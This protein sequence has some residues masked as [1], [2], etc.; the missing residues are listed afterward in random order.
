[1]ATRIT[2]RKPGSFDRLESETFTPKMPVRGEA[3]IAVK[4]AGINFADLCV[5]MGVYSSAKQYVGWPITPGFEIAGLVEETG[6][7]C[8]LKKGDRVFGI[9]RFGGYS[10]HITLPETQLFPLPNAW[11]FA[12]GATFPATFL[13][14]YYALF[15]LVHPRPGNRILIHSAAGGV[16]VALLQLAKTLELQVAAVIGNP[17]KRAA[18]EPYRPDCIIDKSDL[19]RGAK[20]FSPQGY[21]AIF[22]PNGKETLKESYRHLIPS[23]KLVI[24][25]FQTMLTK[26]SGRVHWVKAL[27]DYLLTPRFNPLQMTRDNKSVLAF[28]LSYLFEEKNLFREMIQKLLLL[29]EEKR[30]A[31]TPTHSFPFSQVA[32]AHEALQ[33]GTTTGKL[34][35]E[36]S[37]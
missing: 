26:G 29:V 4:A 32:A 9:T 10:S 31:P 8:T 2:I 1:M 34:V 6:P 20:R 7:E 13:T 30:I 33:S 22:D 23:G 18:I 11:S 14:A 35:L 12:Q 24:Y 37:E 28:N 19:W 25:G 17:S 5:R 3:L 15:E 21:S 27:I 36:L 16:G